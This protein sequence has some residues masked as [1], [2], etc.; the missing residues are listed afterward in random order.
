MEKLS[1]KKTV[2]KAIT[3]PS[4]YREFSF[5]VKRFHILDEIVSYLSILFYFRVFGIYKIVFSN[6]W[7][8]KKSACQ[9]KRCKRC[10]FNPWIGKFSQKRG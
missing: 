7:L 10:G 8:K 4:S 3:T 1:D 6:L 5:Y 9:C 2:V